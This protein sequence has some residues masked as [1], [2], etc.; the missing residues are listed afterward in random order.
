MNAIVQALNFPEEI[1]SKYEII[2][3]MGRG[4]FSTVY[5]IRSKSDNNIYCLKKINIQKTPDRNNEINIL[6][7]LN[8]PNLVQYISIYNNGILYIWRLIFIIAYG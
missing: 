5:K 7:K 1:I 2:Q 8:H 4:A 6:S 3:E